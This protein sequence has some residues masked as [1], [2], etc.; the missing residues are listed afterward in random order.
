MNNTIITI[1]TFILIIIVVIILGLLGVL[2]INWFKEKNKKH[3]K[4]LIK[5]AE[6]KEEKKVEKE[7]NVE[8]IFNFMQFEKIE[9]NMIIEKNGK[10]VMAIEFQGVN[11]DLMSE[12]E[13]VSVEQGFLQFLNTLRYPVQLYI[14]TRTI[15]L[16][17]CITGYKLR[18]KTIE[19][20]YKKMQETYRNMQKSLEYTEKDLEK[21]YYELIKQ[22]NLYE[23]AKDIVY[24]TEKSNF[25]K[26][27]LTKKY[28]ILVSYYKSE[29]DIGGLKSE[30]IQNMAFNELYTRAK[31]VARSLVSAGV[32]GRVLDSEGLIDLLYNAYN[33]DESDILGIQKEI[34]AGYEELYS[35]SPNIIERKIKILDQKISDDAF[36]LAQAK[37]E[38][39]LANEEKRNRNREMN[40]LVMELAESMEAMSESEAGF[41][42]DVMD[43]ILKNET[44]AENEIENETEVESE[45]EIEN[46]IEA[47][48]GNYLEE[49]RKTP[50]RKNRKTKE[51][52]EEKENVVEEKGGRQGKRGRPRKQ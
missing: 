22:K 21:Y 40:N 49:E 23:Y 3:K 42:E 50:K 24:N 12:V 30:E 16:D 32:Q 28:Y 13:K 52:K 27:V 25:N 41:D 34:N 10:Y 36:N 51:K 33:R 15:N 4:Q 19:E 6:K 9:D 18:L 35:T 20:E 39:A 17:N 44:E 48:N 26:N 8:S 11:F 5:Q 46:E 37:V 43:E 14:Q 1:L 2:F 29:M 31:S 47:E 38:K 45:T 7:Y